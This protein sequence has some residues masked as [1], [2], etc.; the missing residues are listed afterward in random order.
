MISDTLE[1]V[2]AEYS[3][4]NTLEQ[5][6]ALQEIMQKYILSSLSKT[7]FFSEAAF[8]GGTCLR[9]LFG[10]TRFSEDLDFLL[11]RENAAFQ[12]EMYLEHVREDCAGEGINFE[13]VD[14]SKA[15]SA[16]RKAFLKTD[17]LGKIIT[18]DLPFTRNE[19]RKIRVK[20]EIDTRPPEGSSFET[21]YITFPVVS[22]ITVQT[23]ESGF[24]LKLHALLCRSYIKGRDW[25]D[26]IWYINRKISPQIDLLKNALYQHGPWAGKDVEVTFPWLRR[27]LEDV[28]DSLDWITVR[29]DVERF[30]PAA[31]LPSMTHWSKAFFLDRLKHLEETILEE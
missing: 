15:E 27:V 29:R 7:G 3:P 11:L 18:L 16:V 8:H 23:L 31:E 24:A 6:N 17:S 30:I 4:A 9:I 5:E 19:H 1:A 10:T 26:F 28:I 2:I 21:R 14:T 22:P 20:L 12:W 25:Y 13:V